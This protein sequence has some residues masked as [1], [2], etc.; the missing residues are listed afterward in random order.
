MFNCSYSFLSCSVP[1]MPIRI[2]MKTVLLEATAL[3]V[4]LAVL[5]YNS[6]PPKIFLSLIP[7]FLSFSVSLYF[8]FISFCFFVCFLVLTVVFGGCVRCFGR[9]DQNS[10]I[11]MDT[12]FTYRLQTRAKERERGKS[13]RLVM[14]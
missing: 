3:T 2:Q 8:C 13:R 4:T 11:C 5:P 12:Q 10:L 6:S 7:S 14:G 1:Q 9:P